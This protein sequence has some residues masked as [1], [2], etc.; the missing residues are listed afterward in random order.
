MPSRAAVSHLV[1][2]EQELTVGQGATPDPPQ[3]NLKV[4]RIGGGQAQVLFEKSEHVLNGKTPQIH[5]SQVGQRHR[6]GTS[7]E[8]M[9]WSL[10]ARGAIGF[11]KLNGQ[12]HAHQEGQLVEVQI[13]PSQQADL[14]TQQR[15]SFGPVRGTTWLR[16]FKLGTVLAGSASLSRLTFWRFLIENPIAAYSHQGVDK[17][18]RQED[19]QKSSIAVQ[20][21]SHDH[22]GPTIVLGQ[23]GHLFCPNLTVTAVGWH[24]TNVQR[25]TP[26]G[27]SC[28]QPHQPGVGVP[29]FKRGITPL[30]GLTAVR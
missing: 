22:L 11:E 24:P 10:E 7:P 25:H 19:G 29:D 3:P 15:T 27:A 18:N 9:E 1:P 23:S 12:D 30:S 17:L 16:E 14:L 6:G 4:G 8:K 13:H 28:H 5:P 21:V 2:D 20:R 26:G